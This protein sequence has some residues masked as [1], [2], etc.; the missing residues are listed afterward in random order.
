MTKH[1]SVYKK[2]L[3]MPD[4]HCICTIYYFITPPMHL[5][6]EEVNIVDGNKAVSLT[7]KKLFS[8]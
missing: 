6:T 4:N 2:K 7:C 3:V 1:V 8:T 5:L